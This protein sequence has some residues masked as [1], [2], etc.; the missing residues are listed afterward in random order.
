[1]AKKPLLYLILGDLTSAVKGISEKVYL[2][3]PKT[4]PVEVTNFIVADI[5]TEVRGRI[6]GSLGVMADCFGTFTIFCKSKDD[7]T[8][9]IEKQS[10]LTQ[11]VLDLF[12]INGKHI[13]ATHP[14]I[15]MQD[16]DGF[17]YHVT[18][19]T[20]KLRTKFNAREI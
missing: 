5:P 2:D 9:A 19:I 8:P 12:P 15:L 7:G 1:M 20:F 13:T 11:K 6:K 18:E 4:T 14:T 17:G 3:R 10:D 16:A